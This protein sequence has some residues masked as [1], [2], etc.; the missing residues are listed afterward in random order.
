MLKSGKIVTNKI[1]YSGRGNIA[2][3]LPKNFGDI[4]KFGDIGTFGEMGTEIKYF[5]QKMNR[6]GVRNDVICQ[7][8]FYFY[9]EFK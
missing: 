1:A 9:K 8:I 3:S 5:I 6:V 4:C 7:P 2:E